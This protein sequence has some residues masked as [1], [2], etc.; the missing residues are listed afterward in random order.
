[1]SDSPMKLAFGVASLCF[2]LW[3]FLDVNR[4]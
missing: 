4:D 3:F 2:L 1:L